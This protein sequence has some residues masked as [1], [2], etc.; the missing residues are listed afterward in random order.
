MPG[1]FKVGDRVRVVSDGF[2]TSK[3]VNHHRGGELEIIKVIQYQNLPDRYGAG[4]PGNRDVEHDEAAGWLYYRPDELEL[5]GH[6][7]SAT[8]EQRAWDE[9]YSAALIQAATGRPTRNPY[10]EAA[11]AGA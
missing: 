8:S 7:P 2:P 4:V 11:N 10:W 5:T 1:K 9:G 6:D 3:I